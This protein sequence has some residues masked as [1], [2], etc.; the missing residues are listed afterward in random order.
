[1][2]TKEIAIQALADLLDAAR[3][4]PLPVERI[5]VPRGPV[6]LSELP[7]NRDLI[8]AP[9]GTALRLGVRALGKVIAQDFTLGEMQDIAHEASSRSG[10]PGF[11]LTVCSVQWHG[12]RARSG[13]TWLN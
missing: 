11:G 6:P 12:I 7:E 9:I 10:P 1:M 5:A 2:L 4:A 3:T 13:A 8:N